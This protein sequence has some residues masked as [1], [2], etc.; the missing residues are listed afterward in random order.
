MQCRRVV[1]VIDRINP[2]DTNGVTAHIGVN[3]MNQSVV[4]EFKNAIVESQE[5]YRSKDAI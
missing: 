3:Q 5:G 2:A 4:K 1:I